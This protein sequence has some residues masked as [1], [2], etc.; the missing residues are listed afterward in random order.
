MMRRLV[1]TILVGLVL[2]ASPLQAQV[3]FDAATVG[4]AVTA[5]SQTTAHTTGS[6]LGRCMIVIA[7]GDATSDLLTTATYN[8]VSMTLVDKQNAAPGSV[9]W[10]NMWSLAN[11][12]SGANNVV[13]SASSS[14]HIETHVATYSG[15]SAAGC[16]Q[17]SAKGTSGADPHV[18]T[19]TTTSPNN[20]T[21][22]GINSSVGIVASTN[23]TSRAAD[24][25]GTY[26]LG[27]SN[28]AVP[29]GSNSMNVTGAGGTK[30]HIIIGLAPISLRCCLLGVP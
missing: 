26:R 16:P 18:A 15:V 12:A 11:P 7:L 21:V 24:A 3:A 17:V 28:A 19:V 5:T 10:Q 4:G 27:D 1:L 30:Q 22:E 25:A 6:G 29:A 14:I 8:G 9:Y 20:W 2:L 13:V 23:F